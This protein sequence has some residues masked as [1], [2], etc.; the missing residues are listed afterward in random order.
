MSEKR[1]RIATFDIY[2]IIPD[3]GNTDSY[4]ASIEAMVDPHFIAEVDNEAATAFFRWV[5]DAV[6]TYLVSS[7]AKGEAR[8]TTL[9]AVGEYERLRV[10]AVECLEAYATHKDRCGFLIGAALKKAGLL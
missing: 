5:G 2:A 9:V 6:A 4:Q 10:F 7:E 1:R 8:E 3:P